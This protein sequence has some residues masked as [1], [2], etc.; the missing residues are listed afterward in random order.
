MIKFD[1]FDNGSSNGHQCRFNHIGSFVVSIAHYMRAYFNDRAL[2]L[3]EDFALPGDAGYLN[4]SKLS[5][6]SSL[7][8]SYASSSEFCLHKCH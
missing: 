8:S 5:H 3:G 1:F 4:V 2:A 7:P 6:I